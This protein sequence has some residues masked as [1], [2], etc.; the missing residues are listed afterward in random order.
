MKVLH[1]LLPVAVA[2]WLLRGGTPTV[3]GEC[4][5]ECGDVAIPYPFALELECARSTDF[6]LTCNPTE[7]N[8]TQLL[9][10]YLGNVLIREISVED[11][12][13]VVSVPKVY[14]CYNQTGYRAKTETLKIDLTSFPPYRFSDTR[15]KFT[16]LGCDTSALISD[17][18]GTFGSGCISY[19]SYN[20]D[21]ANETT[22]SG[23]GCC[24]TSIPQGLKTLRI[25]IHTYDEYSSE[26]EVNP[27]GLAFVVD[28]R[29]FDISHTKFPSF[30]DV[31]ESADLVLDWMVGWDVTCKEAQSNPSGYGCGNNTD[32]SDA[33]NGPGYHC[34]CEPGF[35][36][37][38]YS[39]ARGCQDINECE[40]PQKY[41]CH[42]KCKN[43]PGSYTCSCP[44]GFHGDGKVSCQ[45]SHYV[46]VVAAI[47][48]AFFFIIVGGLVFETWRRRSK[49][50]NFRRNGGE[51]LKHHRVQIFTETELAKATNNYD[52]SN[53][54]GEGGFGSVYRGRTAGG[55]EVAVKKPKDVHASLIK[56]DFHH[57][58]EAVMR[59][60]HKNVVKLDGICLETRIPLLVY[61]YISNGTLFQH[62][63]QNASTIL[64]SWKNRFR[65]AAE[66]ALALIYMHSCAEPPIIH[67]DI[68][69]MNI[70][71]NQN[72]SVKVSDFGTSVLI[73]PEHNH[74]VATE[75]QGTLGYI[76]PE[77]LTTGVLTIKSDVY[78]FGVVLVELLTGKV[79]TSFVTKSGVPINI[80]LCFI[81][82]VKDKT[83][84][85][86][87]NFEGASED[88]ME[89][90]GMVAE[91]AVKCLDQ[92]GAK[93]PAMREV[94]EQLVRINPEHD[95]ST[96][97][98]YNEQTE[99][100]VDEENLDSHATSVTCETS[101]RQGLLYNL[102]MDSAASSM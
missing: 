13:M 65:I 77:Y 28:N 96:V 59:L 24:Q 7:E 100:K 40:E 57:E 92:S 26:L 72:Y 67:G 47:V 34:V 31:G 12:T 2:W 58:L 9:Y 45:I 15:N 49:E 98:E 102:R 19:C 53:K 97:E 82:S 39:R 50:K 1:W 76:D 11:A 90:V 81:S 93:R 84:S 75:I 54:L 71:L 78:S 23:R 42:G 51:L 4:A 41:A 8:D 56:G 69:S 95:G 60:H 101:Q 33:K 44:F 63:H 99:R 48:V 70:L 30:E 3:A 10:P 83:L 29:S 36:G 18:D 79:P 66:V 17:Q 32:C 6:L 20:V 73:S 88:E 25:S 37:N 38:P 43:K 46:G 68:K 87:I 52:D 5:T 55:T 35:K 21:F 16:V 74:I 61:E 89:R 86:V 62:I 85:D 22:C 14:D 80:I 91:I 27:C 64:R 94:A